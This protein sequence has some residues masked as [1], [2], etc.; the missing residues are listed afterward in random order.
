MNL[1][2]VGVGTQT[3]RVKIPHIQFED[4]ILIFVKNE[5]HLRFLAQS[6]QSSC[7][8]SGLKINLEKVLYWGSIAKQRMLT[9]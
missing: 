2:F 7:E 5:S 4:Y 3:E 1:T 6:L 9:G 8:M